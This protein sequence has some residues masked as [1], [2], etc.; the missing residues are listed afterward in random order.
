MGLLG[1]YIDGLPER[2]R[3]RLVQAQDWCVAEVLGP[4]GA[5]CL[6]GH[7]EDWHPLAV[8]RSGWRRWMDGETGGAGEGRDAPRPL[9]DVEAAC[10]PE[11]F[12]FRRAQPGDL[13]VY[14]GRVG[15]WGLSSESRIGSR[16]DRLCVR[17]GKREAVRLVKARA[18]ALYSAGASSSTEN[19]SRSSLHARST[20][21]PAAAA[22]AANPGRSYL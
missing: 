9:D 14:R 5:R 13:E 16:F 4:G 7:A 8:D 1:R 2:A 20:R 10:R 11:I 3:D 19:H 22:S 6:V 15:R 18:S 12:A 17:R 21:H